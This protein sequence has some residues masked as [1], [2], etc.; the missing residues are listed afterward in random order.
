[1]RRSKIVF[2]MREIFL[3]AT[4]DH[5]YPLGKM[6]GWLQPSLV[7]YGEISKP[8]VSNTTILTLADEGRDYQIVD[9]NKDSNVVNLRKRVHE[10]L[11]A[12]L[13]DDLAV[14]CR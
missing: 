7:A 3:S 14:R 4:S 5:W 10:A 11:R 9:G 2:L 13:D 1:M 8:I 12:K 6:V